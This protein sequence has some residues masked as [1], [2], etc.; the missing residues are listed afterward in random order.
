MAVMLERPTSVVD[1]RAEQSESVMR[2]AA[3]RTPLVEGVGTLDESTGYPIPAGALFQDG[4]RAQGV[5]AERRP[6]GRTIAAWRPRRVSLTLA[7]SRLEREHV[8]LLL[9]ICELEDPPRSDDDTPRAVREA[10]L[11]LL[12]DDLRQTQHALALAAQGTYGICEG[13]Q[14]PLAVRLL[15]QHPALTRCA[16]CT[17][18][19]PTSSFAPT[20]D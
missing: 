7:L 1:D 12:R 3:P 11:L 13:C 9:A 14:R 20:S 17:G 4:L 8:A 15:E 2:L 6:R 5:S 10:L 18:R 16:A 19:A